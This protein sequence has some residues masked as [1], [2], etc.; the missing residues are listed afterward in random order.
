MSGILLVGSMPIGN[1]E[2][3]TM[4]MLKE[5]KNCDI[6]YSDYM[7]DNLYSLIDYYQL[8][9]KPIEILKSTHTVFADKQQVLEVI[10]HIKNNKRV[11]LVAGEGQIGIADPGNQFI[12]S[13]IKENLPYTVLP[14]PSAFMSAYVASGST[15]NDFFIS[16]NIENPDKNI[17]LY[18]N[19][20]TPLVMPIWYDDLEK[21]LKTINDNLI[22]ENS[23]NKKVTI[24]VN[25]TTKEELFITDYANKIYNRK[26]IKTIKPFSKIVIVISEFI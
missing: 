8:P 13:C 1:L 23:K 12:Q 17:I 16:C 21:V 19:M 24:C 14:G 4:R 18:K 10:N 15:V 11:M 6:I 7:P 20:N 2:D 25:M 3:I 5:L 9:N 26:E 22:Y